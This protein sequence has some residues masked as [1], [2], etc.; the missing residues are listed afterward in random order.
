MTITISGKNIEIGESLKTF[1][2][3]EVKNTATSY[4]GD[5]IDAHVLLRKR[6]NVFE[7]EID[8]HI[9]KGLSVRSGGRHEDPYICVT[10][11]INTL[12]QR[13]K[14]YKAR[15]LSK[16][17]HQKEQSL[18]ASRFI[19]SEVH[20]EDVVQDSPLI[21]AEM[22]DSIETLNVGE[23]VMRLDLSDIPVLVFKNPSSEKINVLYKRV[24]GNLGWI[25]VK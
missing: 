21:I 5:F 10:Q 13:T 14:R 15:L 17:R 12:K 22:P 25:V 18:E 19:L 1:I 8:M 2:E 4:I 24:D 20:E 9:S 7:C 23:A 11:T 6:N 3:G 16:M